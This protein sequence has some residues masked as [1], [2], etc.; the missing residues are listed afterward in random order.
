MKIA[1]AIF[2]P[3]HDIEKGQAFD[4]D[5]KD[6]GVR[7]GRAWSDLIIVPGLNPIIGLLRG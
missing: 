4:R 3:L 5:P 7:S 1:V 6:G 2:T